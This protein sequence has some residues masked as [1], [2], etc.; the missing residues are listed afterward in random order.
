MKTSVVE[1]RDMLSVLSVDEMEKRIGEVPGA[2]SVT[3]N[4][5]AG[6]V[7]VRY[8]ET[9]LDIAHLKSIVRERGYEPPAPAVS[10]GGGNKGHSAPR[11][12]PAISAAAAQKVSSGAPSTASPAQ[13]DK[14]PPTTPDPFTAD[15]VA[16]PAPVSDAPKDIPA[17]ASEGGEQTDE[18]VPEKSQA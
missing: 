5:A 2:E 7:T 13:P 4:Y 15:T 12:V 18:A 14:A 16:A 8:D 11:A 9:H 10:P 6:T 1:V 17:S 3:V